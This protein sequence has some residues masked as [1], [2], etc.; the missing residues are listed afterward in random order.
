MEKQKHI[1]SALP[2]RD[3]RVFR[4]TTLQT[5]SPQ[6]SNSPSTKGWQMLPS[7]SGATSNT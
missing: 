2:A 5:K 6:T 4:P 7:C 1:L 3:R